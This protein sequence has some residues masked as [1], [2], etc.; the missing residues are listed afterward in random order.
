MAPVIVDADTYFSNSYGCMEVHDQY[1]IYSYVRLFI[2]SLNGTE[3]KIV[4]MNGNSTF[5]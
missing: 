1:F 2:C 5:L 3:V 4:Y